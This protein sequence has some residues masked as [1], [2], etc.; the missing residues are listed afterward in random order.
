MSFRFDGFKVDA[1]ATASMG[2]ARSP[3]SDPSVYSRQRAPDASDRG[4]SYEEPGLCTIANSGW[5]STSSS[6][7]ALMCAGLT[8]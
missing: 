6:R 2:G 4:F 8:T 7:S 3:A 1:E 5:A